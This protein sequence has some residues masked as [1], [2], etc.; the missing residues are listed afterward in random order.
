MHLSSDGLAV[1]GRIGALQHLE[2]TGVYQY[3]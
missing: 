2:L 1:L 3:I